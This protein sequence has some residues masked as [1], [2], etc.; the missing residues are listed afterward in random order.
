MAFTDY[1]SPASVRSLLGVSHEEINDIVVTDDVYYTVLLE[2][3]YMISPTLAED[4]IEAKG[5]DPRTPAQNRFIMLTDT[6]SAYAVATAM[7]TPLPMAAPMTIADGKSELTRMSNPYEGIK[8]DLETALAFYTIK[9]RAAY[10]LVSEVP[11]GTAVTR[12]NVISVGTAINPITG[13]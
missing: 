12:T 3:L 13:I 11:A 4:Y 8:E 1:T 5:L 2:H 9:L 7:A 10:A 6:V